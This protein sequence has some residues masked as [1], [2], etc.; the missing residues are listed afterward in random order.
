MLA[1]IT[2]CRA[3]P[4]YVTPTIWKVGKGDIKGGQPKIT[5]LYETEFV[6]P[7]KTNIEANR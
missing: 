7:P 5:E 2:L 4:Y 3:M 1:Y 6:I